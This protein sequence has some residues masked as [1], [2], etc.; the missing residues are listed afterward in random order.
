MASVYRATDEQT[1][2]TVAVK[3]LELE[4]HDDIARFERET[5]ALASLHHP[6]IVRYIS[7]GTDE[8]RRY[9]VQE[10]VEGETLRRYLARQPV[11]PDE[12][13]ALGVALADALDA[14]HRHGIIHRDVKPENILLQ[15]RIAEPKLADF[16]IARST[17]A[18]E[19][20]TLTG[21]IIGTPAYMAPEQARADRA[22][23]PSVDIW[24]LGCILYEALAQRRAF[25]GSSPWAVRSKVLFVDPAP[26]WEQ[27]PAVRGVVGD[28]VHQ[29]LMKDPASRPQHAAD[30]ATQLRRALEWFDTP[31]ARVQMPLSPQ[32]TRG[33]AS[34][35]QTGK[36]RRPAVVMLVG[37]AAHEPTVVLNELADG[38][39]V[40]VVADD[41]EVAVVAP[42]DPNATPAEAARALLSYGMHLKHH[43]RASAVSIIA[44]QDAASLDAKF[45][46]AGAGLETA[47]MQSLFADIVGPG[48]A[49]IMVDDEVA[50]LLDDDVEVVAQTETDLKTVVLRS[51]A[52]HSR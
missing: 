34:P 15:G 33:D 29:M 44:A 1:G 19:R 38:F 2:A 40:M 18:R 11:S 27:C 12:A 43:A 10:W 31:S 4:G 14:A 42:K 24:A 48:Q 21:V 3:L 46:L 35:T 7:H 6:N 17:D 32:P 8:G 22:L 37:S 16:G 52:R 45:D 47:A 30:I 26:V 9:L 28:L 39:D 20:V 49:E 23:G 36:A 50:A 5:A 13:I 41:D 51:S 25:R